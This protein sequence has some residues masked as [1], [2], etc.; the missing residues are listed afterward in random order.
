MCLPIFVI[1]GSPAS[2][3]RTAGTIYV[4]ACC[5]GAFDGGVADENHED[6]VGM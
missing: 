4:F 5:I 3:Y 2:F 6:M 1:V